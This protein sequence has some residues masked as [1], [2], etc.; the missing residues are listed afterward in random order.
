M[1]EEVKSTTDRVTTWVIEE[2]HTVNERIFFSKIGKIAQKNHKRS[3]TTRQ[4]YGPKSLECSNKA[5][6]AVARWIGLG[7]AGRDQCG[8]AA[9]GSCER[10]EMPTDVAPRSR[11][12]APIGNGV[13][14]PAQ[15]RAV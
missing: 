12:T 5:K 13:K 11:G 7:R 10:K 1:T 3:L 4:N 6:I 8:C 2:N 9:N 14:R 15:R